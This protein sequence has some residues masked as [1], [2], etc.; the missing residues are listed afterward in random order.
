[1]EDLK[2]KIKLIKKFPNCSVQL[3]DRPTQQCYDVVLYVNRSDTFRRSFTT[4]VEALK[5][6]NDLYNEIVKSF[7]YHL[8]DIIREAM[9]NHTVKT[10]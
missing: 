2:V 3:L 10:H 9:Y 4:E 6:F 5:E 1:M 7:E 8:Q